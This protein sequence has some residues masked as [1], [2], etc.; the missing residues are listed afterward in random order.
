MFFAKGR[1][2]ILSVCFR[3]VHLGNTLQLRLSTLKTC[4]NNRVI[5]DVRVRILVN[6]TRIQS[7]IFM[8]LVFDMLSFQFYMDFCQNILI[9]IH[10]IAD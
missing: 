8:D 6:D 2:D 9:N 7:A 4:V 10:Q 1:G 5:P 3:V